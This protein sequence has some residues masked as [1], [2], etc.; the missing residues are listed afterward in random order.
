MNYFLILLLTLI[1]TTGFTQEEESSPEIPY[2]FENGTVAYLLADSVNIRKEPNLKSDAVTQLPIGTKVTIIE[3]SDNTTLLNG[4]EMPWYKVEFNGKK[5][6][7]VWGGKIALNSFRS[8][9]N[10]DYV[11]HFGLEKQGEYTATFQIRV[12]KDHQQLQVV[13]FEGLGS[14]F[15][16]HTCTN[17]SNRG[18]TNVDDV[19]YIDAYSEYC[20]DGGGAI[21]L[22]WS[23]ETL[24][25]IATLYDMMDAPSFTSNYYVFPSD[26][27]GKKD[28][29][30]LHEEDGEYVDDPKHPQEMKID[31]A[32]NA[33]TAFKWDGKQLVKA[34]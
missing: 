34:K 6:G 23:G 31:Y 9:K 22:F 30:L 33:T 15:K 24:F 25:N 12:E 32:K 16:Q 19:I 13:S 5:Q 7:Y 3:K 14:A 17:H 26:M 27:E 21:V 2:F 11:F 18:L 28:R 1:G 29:I 8:S 10:P 4:L 20:G